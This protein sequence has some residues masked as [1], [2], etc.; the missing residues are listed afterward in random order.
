MVPWE[1][2][3][4]IR[5]SFEPLQEGR[6]SPCEEPWHSEVSARVQRLT[7]RRLA[8]TFGFLGVHRFYMR[9]TRGGLLYLALSW[10]LVPFFLAARDA[11]KLE[12]MSDSA[13]HMK[14]TR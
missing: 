9:D 2:R 8:L 7:A 11:A 5:L 3:T 10:T 6:L 13:F 4:S 1:S 12:R 14:V